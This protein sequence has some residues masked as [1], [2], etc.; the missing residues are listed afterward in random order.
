MRRHAPDWTSGIIGVLL[1]VMG[2]G[3]LI[4]N[5]RWAAIDAKAFWAVAVIGLGLGVGASALNQVFAH[6]DQDSQAPVPKD[7]ST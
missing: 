1:A 5:L 3:F 7:P 4:G 2:I 6:P